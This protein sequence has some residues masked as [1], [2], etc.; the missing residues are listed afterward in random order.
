MPI[1]ERV[2][3]RYIRHPAAAN[4][5]LPDGAPLDAGTAH[6]VH[7][8]L[9]HLAA[10]NVRLVGHCTGPGDISLQTSVD[11]WAA[12]W[13]ASGGSD[14]DPYSAIPWLRPDTAALFGPLP[15]AHTR[16]G[17]APAGHYPRKVRVVIQAD[18]GTDSSSTL[19]LYAVLTL[20]AD[21]P[22]RAPR[23]A[24]ALATRTDADAGAWTVEL[25]LSCDA[26]VRPS[27]SWR[28]RARG[29]DVVAETALTPAWVWVGWQSDSDAA[30]PDRVESVSV[31]EEWST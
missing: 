12:V 8:N 26:P 22:R 15:L 9:S 5:P 19:T 28:S 14:A 7:S 16:T 3:D 4:G 21:V 17:T 29:A 1:G 25:T 31:F 2:V 6:L 24:Q 23:I 18:K 10:R 20:G 11:A 27:A 30:D 13:D